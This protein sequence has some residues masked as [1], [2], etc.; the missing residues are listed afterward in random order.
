MARNHVGIFNV[1]I[2]NPFSFIKTGLPYLAGRGHAMT[3][4][5][6]EWPSICIYMCVNIFSLFKRS[7]EECVDT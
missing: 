6:E 7:F 1:Y 5:H 3:Q 4:D 2:S